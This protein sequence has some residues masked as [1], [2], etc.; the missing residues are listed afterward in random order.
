VTERAAEVEALWLNV[1]QQVAGRA[2]HEIKSALNGVSVNLEVVRSRAASAPAGP[3]SGL[4]RFAEAAASQLEDLVAMS[5]A[6]LALARRPREA[7]DVLITAGQLVTLL[8]PA[9]R[10]DGHSLTLVGPPAS[11]WGSTSAPAAAVRLVL[12]SAMLAALDRRS[13]IACRVDG[14]D[15]MVIRLECADGSRIE[16]DPLVAQVAAE[17]AIQVEGGPGGLSLAFPRA[18]RPSGRRSAPTRETA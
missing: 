10:A 16:L 6:L 18:A 17:A 1:L 9:A 4:A 8:G 7:G 13:T 2:A 5:E 3:P 15:G 12:A 14:A 11:G